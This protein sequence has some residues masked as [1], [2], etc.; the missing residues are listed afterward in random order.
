MKTITKPIESMEYDEQDCTWENFVRYLL[1][2][3]LSPDE[4]ELIRMR[5]YHHL[6]QSVIAY[7]LHLTRMQIYNRLD[8]IYDKLRTLLHVWSPIILEEFNDT[9]LS[10]YINQYFKD[11]DGYLL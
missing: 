2:E 11:D 3:Y 7:N 4:K 9:L 10:D 8:A 1:N 6:D 5:Y